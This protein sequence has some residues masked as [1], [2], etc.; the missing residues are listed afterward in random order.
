VEV[1][2]IKTLFRAGFIVFFCEM[3]ASGCF[4]FFKFSTVVKRK[5]FYVGERVGEAVA[6]EGEAVAVAPEGEAVAVA[7][8]GEAVA[9]E[10]GEAGIEV[11][12]TPN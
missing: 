10:V 5:P 3:P 4:C 6:P 2:K 9:A 8:E 11:E 12:G 1:R 7:P